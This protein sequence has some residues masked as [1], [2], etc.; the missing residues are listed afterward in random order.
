MSTFVACQEEYIGGTLWNRNVIAQLA[1]KSCS[2]FHESFCSGVYITRMCHF[3]GEWGY[4]DYSSC[5]MGID[6][7][8]FVMVEIT[9]STDISVPATVNQVSR[10]HAIA[11]YHAYPHVVK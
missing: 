7:T 6:A 9:G 4:I 8:P 10:C 5:T 1:Y 2:S 3:D 11:W